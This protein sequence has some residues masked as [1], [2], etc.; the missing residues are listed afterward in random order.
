MSIIE[1][2]QGQ[3]K[4]RSKT[5]GI[6]S[7]QFNDSLRTERD[8]FK[9]TSFAI[10]NL[11]VVAKEEQEEKEVAVV[12]EMLVEGSI[13]DPFEACECNAMDLDEI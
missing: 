6:V 13:E 10:C 4:D 5:D 8:Q 11:V 7:T 3:T 9:M 2:I 1:T 12:V